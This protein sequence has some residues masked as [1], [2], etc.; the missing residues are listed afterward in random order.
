MDFV[1]DLPITKKGNNVIWVVV[2]RLT[3][4]AHF[5]PMKTGS[6]MHMAP[7]AELFVN[8]IVSRYG[9]PVSITLD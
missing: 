9:Q 1:S 4:S 3:K 6:R 7:F 5:F 2:D 8:E